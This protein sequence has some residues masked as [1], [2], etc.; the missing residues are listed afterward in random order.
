MVKPGDMVRITFEAQVTRVGD[1]GSGAVWVQVNG[2]WFSTDQYEI[3]E[4]Q[5]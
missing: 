2:C 4:E 3:L 5:S 1:P